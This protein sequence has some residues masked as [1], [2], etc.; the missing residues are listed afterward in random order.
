MTKHID[1]KRTTL[2][3]LE[4]GVELSCFSRK[5]FVK[6]LHPTLCDTLTI[7]RKQEEVF[8]SN[9]VNIFVI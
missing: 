2:F 6:L 1:L 8:D 7:K 5:T 9:D 4:K 3:D